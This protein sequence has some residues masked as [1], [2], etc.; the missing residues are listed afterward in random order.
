MWTYSQPSQ[1]GFSRNTLQ[2]QDSSTV[3][4]FRWVDQPELWSVAMMSN[5]AVCVQLKL[6]LRFNSAREAE[7]ETVEKDAAD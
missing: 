3:K 6:M 4:H 7:Q 1:A 5:K 2:T